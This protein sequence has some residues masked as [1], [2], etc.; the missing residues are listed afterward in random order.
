M[1]RKRYTDIHISIYLFLNKTE[2]LQHS[3]RVLFCQKQQKECVL[4]FY[5][6]TPASSPRKKSLL[7]ALFLP[8][9]EGSGPEKQNL[10]KNFQDS[11]GFMK[12]N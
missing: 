11:G 3:E 9:P 7:A 1:G 10:L 5:E 4:S 2:I 12:I 8:Y 6:K